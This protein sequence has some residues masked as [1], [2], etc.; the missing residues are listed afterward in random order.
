MN[1]IKRY[2]LFFRILFF[3]N[4]DPVVK[5]YILDLKLR[6]L[7]LKFQVIRLQCSNI[8]L[9]FRLSRLEFRSKRRHGIDFFDSLSYSI[10]NFLFT[11]R[12]GH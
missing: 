12:S 6:N 3:K 7:T 10:R 5:R 2:F 9:N 4:L 8:V 1:Y 11:F